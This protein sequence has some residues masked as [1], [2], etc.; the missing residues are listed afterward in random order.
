V[1]TTSPAGRGR[2]IGA[3][4]VAVG[5][6]FG[7][8]PLAGGTLTDA[9]GWRGPFL[10]T[11]IAVAAF[12]PM[13]AVFVPNVPGA[14]GQRFDLA[15]VALMC[16]AVTGTIIALNR[17]P[18]N[19]GS[20]LGL[21]GAG[22]GALLWPF[23]V[24]RVRSA[25]DPFVAREVAANGRFWGLSAIGAMTQGGHFAV[26]VLVPLLLTRY[27]GMTTFK[28]GM[29]L[30]PGAIAIGAFGM[31]GGAP[32][33]AGDA[34]AVAFGDRD[35]AWGGGAVPRNAGVATVGNQPLYIARRRLRMINASVVS[36]ATGS[37]R[38]A[39]RGRHEVY[40]PCTSWAR[41]GGVAG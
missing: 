2:A 20:A 29:T 21:A 40:N 33:P 32:Q 11:G 37:S 39:R 30:L 13:A 38:A 10:A 3:T 6:G 17:L 41:G 19:P 7:L 36:A 12:L 31:A 4:G 8:G 34:T 23:V 24:L 14:P 25:P 35:D 9:F 5:V 26:L 22:L 27:H 18:S 15:G 16:G 28:I 1:K